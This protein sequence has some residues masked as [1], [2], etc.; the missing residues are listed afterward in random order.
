MIYIIVNSIESKMALQIVVLLLIT[1]VHWYLH[2]LLIF[3]KY[4]LYEI[5]EVRDEITGME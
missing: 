4:D 5:M 2:L 1:K 3:S